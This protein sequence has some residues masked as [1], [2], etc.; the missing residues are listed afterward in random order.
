MC[1]ISIIVPVY[2]T[3]SYLE[4]CIES[5]M[6]QTFRDIEIICIDDCSSDN[7]KKILEQMSA[8]DKRVKVIYHEQ[9]Q[10]TLQARKHG[11]NRATGKYIMFVDSDDQLEL[12]A[13]ENLYEH[14]CNENVDMIQ[15]GTNLVTSSNVSEELKQWVSNFLIPYEGYLYGRDILK[16]CF[17]EDKFDFNIT[18]KIWKAEL[19]KVAFNKA[20]SIRL[21]ASEDRYLFF[22][23]TFYAKSYL[24]LKNEKYYEYNLGV[25]VTG[26]DTL[27]FEQF[28]KRCSGAKAAEAVRKFL[29][30]ENAFSDYYEE[31]KRFAD[32]ILWDC[33]HCWHKKLD[34]T[35]RKE[36]YQVLKKYWSS[37]DIVTSI[38]RMFFEDSESILNDVYSADS[39][40]KEAV[41]IYYR[42][43]GYDP[44]N[45][46]I[47]Q[48]INLCE[49]LGYTVVLYTDDDT[50]FKTEKFK[51]EIVC[52]PNSAN[53]NWDK[54]LPRA[55]ALE[56]N[57]MKRHISIVLYLS[58]ASHI[59]WL[60]TLL[61][62]SLGI[63]AIYANEKIRIEQ[64]K[65]QQQEDTL[66]KENAELHQQIEDLKGNLEE[67]QNVNTY[68]CNSKEYRLGKMLLYWP[69][70]II[71]RCRI[72][73][74]RN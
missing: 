8:K 20:E 15:F 45:E 35:Y 66:S 33:V 5:L 68:L 24:G 39:S 55:K 6:N 69:K 4:K 31:Y 26:G 1:T 52:L 11:V 37:V 13:C 60:D 27:N 21:I 12:H 73:Q 63:K 71:H 58:P 43:L 2:N 9:N 74:R 64:I 16:K 23:L 17:L 48:Y 51:N 44:M 61:I 3:Q 38:A 36:G 62:R 65:L 18:D 46:Y 57:L 54:Y 72:M 7:S 34:F 40:Q 67:I 41:G 59:A 32:L 50:T 30:S 28:Q 49:R 56:E 25:G 10:G 47:Q 70:K 14:M 19:C 53:A 29:I 42:Y 22:L